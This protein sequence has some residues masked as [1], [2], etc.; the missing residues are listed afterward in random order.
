ML[1]PTC[2]EILVTHFI[3]A[4]DFYVFLL[5]PQVTSR[6]VWGACPPAFEENFEKESQMDKLY[7]ALIKTNPLYFGYIIKSC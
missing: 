2:L 6:G 7:I 1:C 4:R 5:L 3:S